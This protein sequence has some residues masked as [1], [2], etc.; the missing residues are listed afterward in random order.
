[1]QPALIRGLDAILYPEACLITSHLPRPARALAG[2]PL[3]LRPGGQGNLV[4]ADIALQE[5]GLDSRDFNWL[6]DRSA[7]PWAVYRG[8][9]HLC[10]D[11]R[12]L[13]ATDKIWDR[14]SLVINSEQF[15]GLTEAY[16]LLSRAEG[17]RLV[18]FETSRGAS[19]SDVTV[20]YDWADRHETLEFGRLFAS[21][22]EL[23]DVTG[24]RGLRKR[25]VPANAAPLVLVTGLSTRS[26][27][28]PLGDWAA[29]VTKWHRNRPFVI[30][31]TGGEDNDF[32]GQ[33]VNLFPGLATHFKGTF[34]Q[35]CD[36]ISKSEEIL[37]MEGSGVQIASFFGV[38]TLAIFTSGRDRK[39]H[40]LGEGSRVLRRQDL[41]CQPCNKFG[42]VP[43]C[44]NHYA[45][46]KLE[47]IEPVPAFSS[48]YS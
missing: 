14:Y 17:S 23:P 9:A 13:A 24:P 12:P 15:Y 5:M 1:M 20:P 44:P 11:E 6:I 33:L 21:A 35:M 47:D 42:R 26:R 45:C 7:K 22:L 4:C 39:W 48:T 41:P 34:E 18:S 27:R 8:M 40:P 30:A 2:K 28:L 3:V 31:A 10:H 36:Q 19:W 38:P 25:S 32:V 46:H 16:A 37:A 29:L 43:H